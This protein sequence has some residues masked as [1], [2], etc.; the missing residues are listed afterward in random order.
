MLM[1]HS[2]C[3]HTKRRANGRV[4]RP[5][6]LACS[7]CNLAVELRRDTFHQV[8]LRYDTSLHKRMYSVFLI[9]YS[10]FLAHVYE[11]HK[12]TSGATPNLSNDKKAVLSQRLPRDA[13]YSDRTVRQYAHGLLL[14]SPIVPSSTDCWAVRAKIR[15]KRPSRWP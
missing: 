3:R 6:M 5:I 8:I 15:Q 1:Q 2:E 10:Q 7:E 13:P 11:L 14:E 4:D 12:T 9:C